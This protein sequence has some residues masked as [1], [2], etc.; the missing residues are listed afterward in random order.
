MDEQVL[1]EAGL[2]KGEARTY[3]ALLNTGE[4]TVGPI[5][6]EANV[7]LSKIYEILENLIKKGI[8]SSIVKNN[9]KYFIASEPERILEY[10]EKRKQEI[11]ESQDKIKEILP[12]L[13][14]IKDKEKKKEIA[15]L[16][17][18][19]KGIQTFYEYVLREAEA[20]DEI[21]VFGIPREPAEK[22]EA[23]F[24]DWNKRRAKKKVVIKLLFDYDVRDLGKRRAKIKLTQT[25][26]LPK[27]FK[28]PAWVLIFKDIVATIHIIEMPICF[29]IRDKNVS[30]SYKHFFNILWKL[31]EK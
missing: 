25:K 4:S 10:M 27:E 1:Q 21:F 8:A 15:T 9:T 6:K 5:A 12:H 19:F 20:K 14:F 7:S 2:T 24:L 28:T 23:Y 31:A 13:K 3:L 22:Y 17:E 30:K 29:V 11:K 26:Y 16:Y 18:G